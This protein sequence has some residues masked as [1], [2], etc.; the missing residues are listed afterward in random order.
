MTFIT[1]APHYRECENCGASE[2]TEMLARRGAILIC[3]LCDEDMEAEW[4]AQDPENNRHYLDTFS[5][6]GDA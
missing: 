1:P 2:E 3:S 5:P 4:V 6:R